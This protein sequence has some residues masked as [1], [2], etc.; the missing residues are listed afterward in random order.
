MRNDSPFKRYRYRMCHSFDVKSKKRDWSCYTVRTQ[1][2]GKMSACAVPKE[3][4]VNLPQSHRVCSSSIMW[5][6]HALVILL[7]FINGT[8]RVNHPARQ[9]PTTQ[10]N[11]DES[12]ID[13]LCQG[14][15]RPGAA[16]NLLDWS[17]SR[18]WKMLRISITNRLQM[19]QLAL[20]HDWEILV[21]INWL[22]TALSFVNGR[23]SR[24]AS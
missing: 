9:A 23:G 17:T 20:L 11:I 18:A 8:G 16:V 12:T 4:G 7:H 6:S 13:E 22:Y 1:C 3:N 10:R 15:L 14:R 5:L 19:M 21:W 2:W 24:P